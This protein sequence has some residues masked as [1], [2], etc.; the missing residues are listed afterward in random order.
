MMTWDVYVQ[1]QAMAAPTPRPAI[2]WQCPSLGK[3]SVVGRFGM[4]VLLCPM[5]ACVD[6]SVTFRY[7]PSPR[8]GD[9]GGGC[10]GP[11]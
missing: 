3:H 4:V 1:L 11:I 5:S 9:L 10:G 6:R 8:K 7:I 2:E